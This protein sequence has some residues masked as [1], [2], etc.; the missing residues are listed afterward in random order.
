[1]PSSAAAR[2]RG[3]W[4]TIHRWIGIALMLLLIPI[5]LSGGLLVW[6]DEL[7]AF[8][9]PGRFATTGTALGQ[10]VSTYFANAA[11]ALE[12]GLQP[13]VLRFPAAPGRPV[14]VMARGSAAPGS[15]PRIVTVYLDP[16]TGRV[17]DVVDFRTSLVGFLHRF[18]ENLTIPEYSGRQIVGWA[19]VG[20][21]ILSLTGIWLWWPR[22]G[23]F[24]P[25]LRW[26]RSPSTMMNLH[27]LV[28]FWISLPLAVVSATGIYLA[29]PQTAR[30][31]MSSVAAMTPPGARPGFGP[32]E[33]HPT[34]T[35]ERAL[36]AAQAAVTDAT[37]AAVFLPTRAGEARAPAA[38]S[39]PPPTPSASPSWRIQM[40]KGDAGDV[41]VLVEDRSGATRLLPDPLA[42][43][44]AAQ[45][46]RWIHEGSH[47][48]SPWQIA[49]F[50]CGLAPS[51]LAIT[52]LVMWWRA[53]RRRERANG[54]VL[55]ASKDIA[56]ASKRVP[57][58]D[59][60]E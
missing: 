48:G 3:L 12:G 24:V 15:P 25:G 53:R 17:L 35:P 52:G 41:T 55:G 26:R 20:M 1:M 19:G 29:F 27:H 47:A 56:A 36:A 14:T 54:G 51:L 33:R 22:N 43:D 5:S 11:S 42:G 58:L 59:A 18:H 10:P 38:A 16:P 31:A 30:T 44:R 40:R 21:L 34:L 7:D 39:A 60:A 32:V 49:V 13:S 23:A 6:H 2:L 45:W 46:I 8:V 28:G 9:H 37:P 4:R 57:Q 50:L